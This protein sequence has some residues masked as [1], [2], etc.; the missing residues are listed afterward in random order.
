MNIRTINREQTGLFS[1]I[2][3]TL[4]YSQEELISFI[5]TPFSLQ[6]FEKQLALKQTS[7]PKE[8]R[9]SLVAALKKQYA[10]VT[11]SAAV[12]NN[13]DLLE[14][15]TTFTIT[16]GHQLS[17]FTGPLYFIYKIV[18]VIQLCKKLQVQFPANNFVPVFWMASEDHDFEEINHFQLFG[19]KIT[20]E[21]NQKGPVGRFDLDG[22]N[23]IKN[24]LHQF[25]ENHP[26]SYIH[27]LIDSFKGE[28]FSEAQFH[29]VNELFK[30]Y[31]LIILEP[32]TASLKKLFVPTIEKE[33]FER[34]AEEKI[35]NTTKELSQL[36]YKGQVFPRPINFFWIEKGCRERIQWVDNHF[37]IEEKGSFSSEE[38]RKLIYS[39]PENF[40]PN[41]VFRP[42]YQETILPNLCYVGGGGE[43]AYWLQLKAVFDSVNIPYPLIQ[44]R[45]SVQLID[46]GSAKKMNRLDVS[47]N[48]FLSDI[49]SI[50]KH[51]VQKHTTDEVNFDAIQLKIDALKQ[52]LSSQ[53]STLDTQLESFIVAEN[54]K[55]D[56]QLETIQSKVL[57]IQKQKM[58]TFMK[59]LEDIKNKLFPNG[60]LQER[61]ESF[62][63]FC[64]TGDYISF[65]NQ[66]FEIINPFEKDFIVAEL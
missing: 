30:D 46:A 21:S 2:S 36:S 53:I 45:N 6:A 63:S 25:F 66:I 33:L 41:V 43:M 64:P 11:T 61:T 5:Q 9:T 31:G 55:L 29:L 37:F 51:Y 28:N 56:K 20:W 10:S 27:S 49:D 42:V 32:D 48:E 62:L 17:L 7:Y 19:K 8:N 65:I 1:A 40:S 50:K 58:E 23:E 44:V 4:T 22:I 34:F 12:L 3:N 47:F 52:L 54:N 26:D 59:Q 14:K 57:R 24:E 18:H 38:M 15:E 35:Q 16:T 39:Q 13:I 60:H